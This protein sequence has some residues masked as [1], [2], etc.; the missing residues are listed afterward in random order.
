[1]ALL[2]IGRICFKRSGK[3]AGEKV[4]IVGFEGKQPVIEGIKAKRKKCN[5]RHLFPTVEKK[6][7]SNPSKEEIIK[8]LKE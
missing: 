6:E 4:I 3:N 5:P 1:M 7:I 2:E 8:I